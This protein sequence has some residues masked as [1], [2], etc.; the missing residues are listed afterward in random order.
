MEHHLR[1]AHDRRVAGS[2]RQSADPLSFLG[3]NV[4]DTERWGMGEPLPREST[5]VTRPRN[6]VVGFRPRSRVIDVHRDDVLSHLFPPIELPG[7]LDLRPNRVGRD[8]GG[9]TADADQANVVPGKVHRPIAG[10][11]AIAGLVEESHVRPPGGAGLAS[12]WRS[13]RLQRLS[14]PGRRP[15]AAGQEAAR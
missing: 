13:G 3:G 8:C 1:P 2:V 11:G 7:D 4:A 12:A 6:P 10:G 14:N 9:L 5:F 15:I